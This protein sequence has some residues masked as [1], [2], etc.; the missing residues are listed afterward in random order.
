MCRLQNGGRF[1]SALL[2][3]KQRRQTYMISYIK[4]QHHVIA[5]QYDDPRN[6]F[7][8]RNVKNYMLFASDHIKILYVYV[9]G[10]VGTPIESILI[11]PPVRD[12]CTH[13]K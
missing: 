2:Y 13:F 1:V 12:P 8:L 3:W 4:V 11:K 5:M 6:D 9:S 7:R 10:K